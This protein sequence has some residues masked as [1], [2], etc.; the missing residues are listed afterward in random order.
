MRALVVEDDDSVGG[1]LA[2]ALARHGY[3]VR[4][5]WSGAEALAADRADIVLLD[6]GLPDVDGIELCRTLRERDDVPIVA[7]TARG[8][9]QARVRGLRSGADDYVVKPYALGELLARMEAVLRRCGPARWRS[10]GARLSVGD[11]VIDPANRTAVVAGRSLV[12]TRKEFELLALLARESPAVVP[13]DRILMEVWNTTFEGVSS[14]LNVHVAGLRSKLG[15]ADLIQTVRGV[16][17]RLGDV[18][19]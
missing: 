17:Y 5:A 15:R 3:E 9:Q 12:L 18:T 16:G 2:S 11:L 7:V 14:T 4:R 13:R 6:L 10:A 19:E 8:D 1:A